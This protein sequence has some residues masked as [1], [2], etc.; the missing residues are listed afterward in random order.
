MTTSS[1]R[2]VNPPVEFGT[3]PRRRIRSDVE[4]VESTSVT[5]WNQSPPGHGH[6]NRG[7]ARADQLDV[8]ARDEWVVDPERSAK[9]LRD[10]SG[11]RERERSVVAGTRTHRV[12]VHRSASPVCR[13][14]PA[15]IAAATRVEEVG[16]VREGLRSHGRVTEERHRFEVLLVRYDAASRGVYRARRIDRRGCRRVR[17]H[18]G[19]NDAGIVPRRGIRN[20][21][22][23]AA[24]ARV[25][26][27]RRVRAGLSSVG[28]RRA[29]A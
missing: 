13:G 14:R 27:R 22:S 9:R 21:G 3:S 23:V 19:I 11:R 18:S 28:R 4:S 15:E 12:E 25:H 16:A 26:R 2:N 1:M 20:R 10:G 7:T 6:P 24:R 17:R 29:A 5:T 8:V